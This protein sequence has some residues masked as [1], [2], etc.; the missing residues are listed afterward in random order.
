MNFAKENRVLAYRNYGGPEV[1]EW[2]D[3]PV[4]PPGPGECLV[5]VEAISVNPVDWKIMAGEQSLF[6]GSRL[7]RP[8]IFGSDY[9]GTVLA[10][11][12]NVP[13]SLAGQRVMGMV[14]PLKSGS[15]QTCLTVKAAS[16]VLLPDTLDSPRGAALPAAGI[17][18]WRLWA[19]RSSAW[20][21]DRPV[22]LYGA[23]G[24]V[25]HLFAQL[26]LG[27]GAKVTALTRPDNQPALARIGLVDCQD[28]RAIDPGH[29]PPMLQH[30]PPGSRP[31]AVVDCHGC[32]VDHY[33]A[34][35]PFLGQPGRE[36]K[37]LGGTWFPL[38]LSNRQIPRAVA[39]WLLPWPHYPSGITLAIPSRRILANLADQTAS[40]RLVP[41]VDAVFGAGQAQ[42]AIARSQSGHCCGKIIISLSA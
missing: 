8:R 35:F 41:L 29:L 12:R 15:G 19:Q 36:L 9:A 37:A 33:L 17:S 31:P 32:T 25:G 40:G 18:A 6:T 22:L 4:S 21:Q 11:G 5:Q 24:G 27:S 16:L 28:Y 20:W 26:A 39:G 7:T 30:L 34:R 23:S 38:S 3:L 14:N 42:A 10:C 13:P 2:L 1:L